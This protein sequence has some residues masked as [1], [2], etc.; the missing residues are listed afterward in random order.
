MPRLHRAHGRVPGGVPRQLLQVPRP[1]PRRGSVRGARRGNRR[2]AD[3][4]RLGSRGHEL[5]WRRD[6]F[7]RRRSGDTRARAVRQP[8]DAGGRPDR[9]VRGH[10]GGRERRRWCSSKPSS[11]PRRETRFAATTAVVALFSSFADGDGGDDGETFEPDHPTWLALN[12]AEKR[13]TS[14]LELKMPGVTS[15]PP[16][17]SARRSSRR[18]RCTARSSV[19]AS[20]G[21]RS[22]R[23]ALLRAEPHGRHRRERGA[24]AA[25]GRARDH[26]RGFGD[27]GYRVRAGGMR[28][29]VAREKTKESPPRLRTVFSRCETSVKR[30][31]LQMRSRTG[32]SPSRYRGPGF[33]RVVEPGGGARARR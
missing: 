5:G 14:R 23:F 19:A 27:G 12:A 32:S 30:R 10:R 21:L 15:H 29:L 1:R 6:A 9:D 8:R 25:E 7:S 33:G 2:R 26:R 31:G 20:S 4:G 16:G 18:S 3:L 24:G 17:G 22:R 13:V 28:A 11:A